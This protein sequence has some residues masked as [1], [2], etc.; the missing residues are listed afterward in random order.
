MLYLVE[1]V[2]YMKPYFL[3]PKGKRNSITDVGEIT[4]GHVTLDQGPIQTGITLVLPHK[5]N[6]FQNKLFAASHIIN[7][8]GKSTGFVQVNELGSIESPI[9][10]TNTSSTGL[11]SHFLTKYM[12]TQDKDICRSLGTI[13]PLVLECNDGLINDQRQFPFT[14]SHFMQALEN[15]SKDFQ[16]GD[17]GAGRGMICYGFKGGIGSSSRLVDVQ[18][19]QGHVGVLVLSNFGNPRNLRVLGQTVPYEGGKKDELGDKGSICIVIATDLPLLPHQ[20]KRVAKRA[21]NGIAR[22]GSF[23][24]HGSGDVVLA[25]S[26]FEKISIHEKNIVSYSSYPDSALDTL[27]LATVEAVEEAIL[28]SLF[29]SQ[30]SYRLDGRLVPNLSSFMEVPKELF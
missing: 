28:Q 23:T 19:I 4:V 25:F 5:D 12:I 9:A 16:Q 8:Y 27:F 18:S 24:G 20:L 17:V 1:E 2:L 10:L 3:L 30:A 21:Q 29:H 6:I 22:T 13:N 26:T 14:E 11:V 15:L 7:G